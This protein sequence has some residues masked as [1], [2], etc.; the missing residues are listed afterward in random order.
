MSH[1][2]LDLQSAGLY[3]VCSAPN[4]TNMQ[5]PAS[6]QQ[7][8]QGAATAV[9]DSLEHGGP[10]V[11]V[12]G[13]LPYGSTLHYPGCGCPPQWLLLKGCRAGFPPAG[14]AGTS[15]TAN[16]RA[17]D[18]LDRLMTRCHGLLSADQL[19]PAR[20]LTVAYVLPHHNVTGGMKC[21]VEHIRL[22]RERGH[23]V[24][25]VHRWGFVQSAAK[26]VWRKFTRCSRWCH[27][28]RIKSGCH[29]QC[30]E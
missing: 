10:Q 5:P 20:K 26:C 9:I 7:A 24:A 4:E 13:L 22:L 8:P 14:G 16:Q 17:C 12:P 18:H 29:N 1:L 21:L 6:A 30:V 15:C 11:S 23:Y 3:Q 2:D 19:S 27:A 25:A 28:K